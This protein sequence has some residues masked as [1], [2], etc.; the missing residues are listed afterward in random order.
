ML[1]ANINKVEFLKQVLI[2][3]EF[4][5]K[6]LEQVVER[7]DSEFVAAGKDIFQQGEDPEHFYIIANGEV[8]ITRF[9]K[10]GGETFL[11]NFDAGDT[12]GED[13]LIFNRRRSATVTA[14]KDTELLLL[15]QADFDWLRQTYPKIDPYLVAF[16]RTHETIRRLKIGWLNQEETISLVARRHPFRMWIEIFS[17]LIFLSLT[18]VTTTVFINFLNNVQAVIML[19]LGIA[20]V[21]TLLGI[22]ACIWTFLEWRN[23]YFFITNLRV[24]WR[25]RILFRSA[26]R[27][28]VPLRAIQSIDVETP[29]VFA[30]LIDIGTLVI[31]TFNSQM[32]LTDVIHPVRMK[33]MVD[34]FLQKARRKTVWAEHAA[35]RQTI[36]QRLGHPDEDEPEEAPAATL[37]IQKTKHRLTIFR[38]RVVEDGAITYRK[39]WW[40]F[41]GRAWLPSLSFLA[42]ALLAFGLT[43]KAFQLFGP[44]GL[45]VLYFIPLG[46]FLWWL[47]NYEDWRNDIYRVTRD[48]IIDRDKKPFGK[49]SFRSAPI[50]N[51]QSVGHH[52]PN[53]IGLI[54]NVGDVRI[55]V[56]EETFTFDGVHDP[57]LVHQDISRR[58]EE[59]A[60]ATEQSRRKEEH[61][62]MATWL[63]I[64]HDELRHEIDSGSIE[65]IPDFD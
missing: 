30:R 18:L 41:F 29:N 35:I 3:N 60:V 38:T 6:E 50:K 36:R 25:E 59:L 37:D 19:S 4:E 11:A 14:I 5:E 7:L 16:V 33:E 42:A 34:A 45:L 8:R 48:R 17:I 64:Y 54:L 49:E 1:A 21:I 63:E 27:Q 58:M 2:F 13:A 61:E 53:T 62:R 40:I 24:V 10:E 32:G 31:R 22:I 43:I 20:G 52:I 65:H 46:I 47:Y 56:G 57:A 51:I 26:S 39:H 23:D 28:E 15:S 44:L 55:K 9:D 12:F